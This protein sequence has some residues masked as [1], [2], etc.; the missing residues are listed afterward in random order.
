MERSVRWDFPQVIE[1]G[2]VEVTLRIAPGFAGSLVVGIDLLGTGLMLQEG[3]IDVLT[4]QVT[5]GTGPTALPG[6]G[7]GPPARS[8]SSPA[9]ELLFVLVGAAAL[10]ASASLWV[11]GGGAMT[12]GARR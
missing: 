7:A 1:S 5:P 6:T 9:P 4:T 11:L 2:A 3:S 12:R 8:G 10:A